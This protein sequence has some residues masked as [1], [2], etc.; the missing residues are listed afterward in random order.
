MLSPHTHTH[1]HSH[2]IRLVYCKPRTD[3]SLNPYSLIILA[4]VLFPPVCTVLHTAKHSYTDPGIAYILYSLPV[5]YGVCL[6]VCLSA[7]Y[8]SVT[9]SPFAFLFPFFSL[10]VICMLLYSICLLH[11]LRFHPCLVFVYLFCLVSFSLCMCVYPLP[12]DSPFAIQ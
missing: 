1:S 4:S 7:V 6:S 12:A 10:F 3:Y 11:L 5:L 8:F 9:L 2:E